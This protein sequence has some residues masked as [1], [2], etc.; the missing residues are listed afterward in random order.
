M[1][2]SPSI[3]RRAAER[4]RSGGLRDR[5]AITGRTLAA[6][7]L[8]ILFAGCQAVSVPPLSDPFTQAGPPPPAVGDS[9]VYRIS[10]G[11]NQEVRGQVRYQVE[12]LDARVKY[13]GRAGEL[14]LRQV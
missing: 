8:V 14:S 12:K 3:V 9:W 4:P 6:L 2:S 10:N 5:V 1:N 13:S 11:Y 7:W